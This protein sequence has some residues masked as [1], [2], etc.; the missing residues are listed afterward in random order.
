MVARL[1]GTNSKEGRRLLD[2]SKY[3]M[4]TATTLATAAQRAVAAARGELEA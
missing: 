4:I 1:V 2:E 3:Q